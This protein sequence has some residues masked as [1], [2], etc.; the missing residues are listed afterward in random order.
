MKFGT[1]SIYK[2]ISILKFFFQIYLQSH[3]QN[4]VKITIV[5]I[6]PIYKIDILRII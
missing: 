2:K 1:Q 6:P 5:V 3:C 4:F